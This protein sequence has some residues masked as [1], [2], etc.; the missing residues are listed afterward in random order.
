MKLKI[1][2]YVKEEKGF[3]QGFVS[4]LIEDGEHTRILRHVAHLKKN[5]SEWFS[6]PSY[7]DANGVF[8]P[9]ETYIDPAV[10]KAFIDEI[11]AAYADFKPKER[12]TGVRPAEPLNDEEIPF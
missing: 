4:V 10:Q 11:K 6:M 5:E 8:Q 9:I 12:I 2:D 1:L 3:R 7:K